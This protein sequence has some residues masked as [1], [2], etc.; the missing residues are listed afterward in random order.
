MSTHNL[1]FRARIKKM[2]TPVHPSFTIYKWGVRRCTF[3]GHVCMMSVRI[4]MAVKMT[5]SS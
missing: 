5:I 1:C 4:L 2:Y 3:H